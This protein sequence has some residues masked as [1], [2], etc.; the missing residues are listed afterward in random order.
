MRVRILAC[1]K[2]PGRPARAFFVVGGAVDETSQHR[3]RRPAN[4]GHVT[5]GRFVSRI[6]LHRLTE[7]SSAYGSPAYARTALMLSFPGL[8][9]ALPKLCVTPSFRPFGDP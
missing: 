2:K 7:S 4:A 9:P 3:R 5:T 8:V 1:R 6:W